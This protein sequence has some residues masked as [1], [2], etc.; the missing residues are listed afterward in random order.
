MLIAGFQKSSLLDYPKKISAVIFTQGC[1]MDCSYCHNRRI[2]EPGYKDSCLSDVEI[3]TFLMKRKKLLDGVVVTGGEP[4]LQKDLLSFISKVKNMGYSIKLDTNGTNPD[5]LN[6]LINNELIDYVAMDIKAPLSNYDKIC[7][8]K[9]D[10]EKIKKSIELLLKG[11]IE[12]EFRTTYVPGLK[13]DDLISICK[14]IEGAQ[15]YVVQQYKEVNSF[16]GSYTGLIEKRN[17]IK[18]VVFEI[19]RYVCLLKFRGEFGII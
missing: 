4:T 9:V 6:E 12:Y 10:T 13:E 8:T 5:V 17:I 18:E 2:I 3:L 15:Q 14:S 11:N 19:K 16:E 7:C 1:N